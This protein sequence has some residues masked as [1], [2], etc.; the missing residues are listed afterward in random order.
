VAV[1]LRLPVADPLIVPVRAYVTVPPTGRFTIW[2]MLPDPLAV[3]LP[4]PAPTQVHVAPVISAG[5]VSVTVAPFAR[6]GPAFDTT[7]VYVMGCPVTAVV[8]PSVF[9]IERSAPGVSVSV[10]VAELLARLGSVAPPPTV[11]VAVL[12]R[13]PVAVVEMVQVAV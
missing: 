7:I 5:T 4:P 13:L 2:L 8:C 3:Q 12:L 6:L 1:L 11:A 10:S 9:V